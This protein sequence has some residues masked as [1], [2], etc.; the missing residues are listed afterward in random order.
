[1]EEQHQAGGRVAAVF[2][3]H[4]PRALLQAHGFL[5][6]EVWGPPGTDVGEADA[7]LQSYVCDIVRRGLGFVLAGGLRDCDCLLVPH[8]CDS[9][10]GLGSILLD[11][12]HPGLPVL[13]FYLARGEGPAALDFTVAELAGLSQALA[14][15][16]GRPLDEQ[17]WNRHL[18]IEVA[19]EAALARLWRERRQL[20]LDNAEL[21]R[22]LRCRNY[23]AADRFRELLDKVLDRHRGAAP[24]QKAILLGGIVA[25]PVGLLEVI[26]R[27]GGL[28]VGDA[29]CNLGRRLYRAVDDEPDPARRQA[30]RLLGGPPDATRG[31]APSRIAEHLLEQAAGSGARALVVTNPKFCE[32]ELFVLPEVTRLLEAAGLRVL[33]LELE[34]S[35]DL[36]AAAANRLEAFLET[37]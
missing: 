36:P 3:I 4:Y 30:R 32:P 28:V 21:Y 34:L 9:L 14:D 19:A 37:L 23:L 20:E 13:T 17:A 24:G 10:Q 15:I 2:P 22:L 26:D 7:H 5:P 33:V 18:E 16:S 35:R 29:G 31:A 1:M 12:H 6:I 27:A 25:E 8:G 11:F